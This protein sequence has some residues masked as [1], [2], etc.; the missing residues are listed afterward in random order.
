MIDAEW[1]Y[2]S[3]ST[4][5][6]MLPPP[7]DALCIA[8]SIDSSLV[9]L[10]F[11]GSY[12]ISATTDSGSNI[13]A[14]IEKTLQHD[15]IPCVNHMTHNVLKDCMA[16]PGVAEVISCARQVCVMFRRAPKKW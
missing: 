3:L 1:K 4:G 2:L 10:G 5:V 7:H 13:A 15:W 16:I 11:D 6:R 12:K 14:A 9:D 8:Q